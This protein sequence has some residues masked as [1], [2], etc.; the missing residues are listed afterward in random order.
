MTSA[1]FRANVGAC[2]VDAQGHVLALKRKGTT[3]NAWQMPPRRHR[4]ARRPHRL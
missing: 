3:D 2:V 1:Y 4:K